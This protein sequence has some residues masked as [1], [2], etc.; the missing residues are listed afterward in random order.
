MRHGESAANV[1]GVHAGQRDDSELT[2]KGIEQAHSAAKEAKSSG[3]TLDRIIASR[4][5]RAAKTA[6]IFGDEF[7]V[8]IE[9]DDR[10]LEYD[11]GLASGMPIKG[12]SNNYKVENPEAEDVSDFMNRVLSIVG[13]LKDSGQNI[14]LVSHGGVGR[15]IMYSVMDQKPEVFYDIKDIPNCK[16]VP[17]ESLLG[18]NQKI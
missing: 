11:M 15:I 12:A 8:E 9:F 3:M 7:G 1:L 16:I 14:L 13:D 18:S 5:K 10:L 2:E 17:I 6:E 4:L